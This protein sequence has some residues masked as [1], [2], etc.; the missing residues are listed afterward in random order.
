MTAAGLLICLSAPAMLFLMTLATHAATGALLAAFVP[1]HPV[2]AFCLGFGSHFLL[3]MVPHWDYRLR[4][5]E[6]KNVAV[7]HSDGTSET[8][9]DPMTMKMPFG[10]DFLLDLLKIGFDFFLGILVGCVVFPLI[11]HFPLTLAVAVGAVSAT[12]P[13]FLTFLYT[14]FPYG[15]LKTIMEFH[16]KIHTAFKL[17]DWKIGFPLQAGMVAIFAFVFF[18]IKR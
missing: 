8:E 6:G 9:I 10:R 4:S 1:E 11:F 5:L 7:F 16:M 2:V 13:D 3:D 15:I 18:L 12:L 17:K 14:K